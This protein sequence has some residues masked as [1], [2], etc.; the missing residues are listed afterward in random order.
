MSIFYIAFSIPV[1]GSINARIQ[2]VLSEG[3]LLFCFFFFL[4]IIF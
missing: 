4:I 2:R 1:S 3:V